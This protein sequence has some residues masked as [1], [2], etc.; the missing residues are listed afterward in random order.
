MIIVN[1]NN[2]THSINFR[3]RI[4]RILQAQIN[5]VN[6]KNQ[7]ILEANLKLD[8]ILKNI[9]DLNL[10]MESDRLNSLSNNNQICLD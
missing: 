6:E 8:N 10:R 3:G 2:R 9:K 4:Q 1:R 5:Y 7:K